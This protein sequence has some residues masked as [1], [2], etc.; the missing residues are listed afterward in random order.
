MNRKTYLENIEKLTDDVKR[1]RQI[2]YKNLRRLA[3]LLAI[4]QFLAI[5]ITLIVFIKGTWLV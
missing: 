5:V 3:V 4:G 1:G 2:D